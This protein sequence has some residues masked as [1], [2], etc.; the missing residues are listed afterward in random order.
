MID[1]FQKLKN[2]FENLKGG[3]E[4]YYSEI[5]EIERNTAICYHNLHK[6][7]TNEDVINAVHHISQAIQIYKQYSKNKNPCRLLNYEYNM[8]MC[9][10]NGKATA[11]SDF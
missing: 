11:S 1:N 3:I 10:Y 4:K 6:D 7:K 2:E 5:V 8:I 9:E